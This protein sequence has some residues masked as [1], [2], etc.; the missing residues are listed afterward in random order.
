MAKAGRKSNLEPIAIAADIVA[1]DGNLTAVAKK[2]SVDRT[3]VVKFVGRNKP[4][5]QVLADAREGMLDDAESSLYAAVRLGQAWA[6]CFFLKTQGRA[7]GYVER[8]QELPPL[9][10]LLGAL[11]DDIAKVVRKAL[12]DSLRPGGDS[13]DGRTVVQPHPR[14]LTSGPDPTH[15]GGGADP[16]PVAGGTY[17][18]PG[19]ADSG[20]L[21]AAQ[22]EDADGGGAGDGPLLD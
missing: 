16:R 6:V 3:T 10:V 20:T 15:D 11:P 19:A 7:R 21:H 13:G 18:L 22:R 4:L 2:H 8:L 14:P 9:E 1:L 17:R 5:Q 12:A